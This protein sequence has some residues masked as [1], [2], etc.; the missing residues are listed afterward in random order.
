MEKREQVCQTCKQRPGRER[1]DNGLRAGVHCDECWER[2]VRECR[3]RS[4]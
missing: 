1:R 2:M 4:W 3:S